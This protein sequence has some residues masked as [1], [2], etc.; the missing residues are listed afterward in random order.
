ML[1]WYNGFSPIERNKKLQVSK[2]LVSK[3]ALSPA[4]GPCA[5]C[6]D[7]DVAVEYHDE[8]YGEPYIWTEPALFAL[9]R[10]C[11][12]DKLHKRFWRHS[13]WQA[14][15]AHVR[16]GGYARDLKNPAIK[17]E[18]SACQQAIEHGETYILRQLRPYSR[19]TG[20]EWFANLRMDP[21]S[22]TDISAR[23]RP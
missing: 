1:N 6:G 15:I 17:R 19:T 20:L 12:R 13:A 4:T 8:D 14:F 2:R 21:E 16:R 18:V 23:P 9:C 7:P 10:N 22:L 11:H 3:G 5:I